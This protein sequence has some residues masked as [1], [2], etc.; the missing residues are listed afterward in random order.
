[1]V[2]APIAAIA[3]EVLDLSGSGL[4]LRLAQPLP[5]GIRIEVDCGDT[6][7]TGEVCRC[8]LESPNSPGGPFVVGI[9]LSQISASPDELHRFATRLDQIAMG[10][11]IM[12]VRGNSS[13]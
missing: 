10:G 1:M 3:A 9:H 4:R 11:T 7:G 12:P 8:E 5:C 2:S 13:K 6:A